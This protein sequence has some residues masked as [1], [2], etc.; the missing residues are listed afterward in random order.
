MSLNPKLSLMM[1][2]VR[3][4]LKEKKLNGLFCLVENAEILKIVNA[5]AAELEL[6]LADFP[7]QS[8]NDYFLPLLPEA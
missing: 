5:A 3:H 7:P 6:C 8:L 1:G 2:L 4:Y